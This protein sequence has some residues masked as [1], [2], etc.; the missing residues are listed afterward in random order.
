MGRPERPSPDDESFTWSPEAN[1]R[2]QALLGLRMTAAQRLRWLE[3][4][5]AE[6]R[7][8]LGKARKKGASP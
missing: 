8:I 4:T 3:T 7:K 6:M 5:V 2:R 1:R